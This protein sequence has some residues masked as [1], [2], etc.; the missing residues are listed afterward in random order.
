MTIW[1][2]ADATP[3]PVKEILFRAAE[4]R[5]VTIVLVANSGQ[6]VP[7]RSRVTW[8]QVPSG[9]DV[10]DDYIADQCEAGDL[11]ITDDVP[12]AARVV[13]RGGYALQP[14]GDLLDA[15]NVAERL[16]IRDFNDGLRGD[17]VI[18]GGPAPFGA[19]D[20]QRFA[21]ALDRWITRHTR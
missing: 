14:R 13:E 7:P 15:E 2:D 6:W 19:G 18:T 4:K 20:R 17:G 10:A 9:P 11:V 21:N 12:L 5:P 1:V 3:R 16:S 8:V